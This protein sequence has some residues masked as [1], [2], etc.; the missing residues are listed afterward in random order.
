MLFLVFLAGAKQGWWKQLKSYADIDSTID[1]SS[2]G[3][4]ESIPLSEWH[5]KNDLFSTNNIQ[6]STNLPQD[7]VSSDIID[8]NDKV[9]GDFSFR[10]AGDKQQIGNLQT[11]QIPVL[12]SQKYRLTFWLKVNNR[13]CYVS[14]TVKDYDTYALG[15]DPNIYPP[16]FLIKENAASSDKVYC[17]QY[18]V[19]INEKNADGE[20]VYPITSAETTPS[21][22][23]YYD[24]EIIKLTAIQGQTTDAPYIYHRDISWFKEEVTFT[25]NSQTQNMVFA[26][27]LF[28]FMGDFLIDDIQLEQINS[29]VQDED[30][31]IP[32]NDKDM[33]LV[34]QDNLETITTSAKFN[35]DGQN[36]SGFHNS[37]LNLQLANIGFP[38]EAL[39]DLS[40]TET[41]EGYA[42]YENQ[43]LVLSVGADS[44][45]IIKLKQPLNIDVT[46]V[47]PTYSFFK[48]GLIFVRDTNKNTSDPPSLKYGNGFSFMPILGSQ[49]YRQPYIKASNPPSVGSQ[50]IDDWYWDP[51]ITTDDKLDPGYSINYNAQAGDAF[52]FTIFPP[53]EFNVQDFCKTRS[54]AIFYD[55]SSIN[56]SINHYTA[57]QYSDQ[58]N[59]VILWNQS[60]AWTDNFQ[61]EGFDENAL[62]ENVKMILGKGAPS[63]EAG[64]FLIKED[65]ANFKN[66]IQRM[67]NVGSKVLVY[68]SPAFFYTSKIGDPTADITDPNQID[69]LLSNLKYNLDK[70]EIDGVY[71]DGLYRKSPM[72]NLELMRKTRKLLGDKVFIQHES[73]NG[74]FYGNWRNPYTFLQSGFR[75]PVLDAYADLIWVGESEQADSEDVFLNKFAGKNLSNS[76]TVLLMENRFPLNLFSNPSYPD[77]SYTF[78]PGEID[79]DNIL[80]QIVKQID[81]LGDIYTAFSGDPYIS[82]ARGKKWSTNQDTRNYYNSPTY[83]NF[84]INNTNPIIDNLDYEDRLNSLCGPYINNDNVCD[85]SENILDNPADCIQLDSQSTLKKEGDQYQASSQKPLANWIISKREGDDI[86]QTPLFKLHYRADSDILRDVS[87]YKLDPNY[88]GFENLPQ[89]VIEDGEKAVR[90]DRSKNSRIYTYYGNENKKVLD[91]NNKSIS[92]FTRLKKI[93]KGG[94]E[95][96]YQRIFS[97]DPNFHF[98]FFYNRLRVYLP[99]VDKSFENDV[100]INDGL[101]HNIGFVYDQDAHTLA[102]YIDGVQTSIH[103][104]PVD[105]LE[106][107]PNHNYFNLGS[108][109]RDS[110]DTFDGFLSEF[111]IADSALTELQVIEMQESAQKTLSISDP[112][113]IGALPIFSDDSNSYFRPDSTVK[114]VD[115]SSASTNDILTYD[116]EYTNFTGKPI[117]NV[118]ITDN[119]P[120]GT[121]YVPDSASSGGQYSN[122]TI[123][124]HIDNL[125]YLETFKVQFQ[126][127]VQ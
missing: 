104:V 72:K 56:D 47:D 112:D 26:I 121:E 105:Y 86:T 38:A 71:F 50:I 97:Y 15:Y 111:Y 123:Q 8:Y 3:L 90:Y 127:K 31:K 30:L 95:D 42:I 62:P 77:I 43:N 57:N 94:E 45:M 96:I 27:N 5:Q 93:V 18:N 87:G 88:R 120:S 2:I 54:N 126:V 83:G 73:L 16:S 102:F 13:Q 53:K 69:S 34:F 81:N 109:G 36:I 29:F 46:G 25:S 85:V 9:A 98:I 124:W 68:M 59:T 23:K 61:F 75:L 28:G 118:T 106:F 67:H 107:D 70:Y 92:V 14:N 64:P 48:N 55:V 41:G 74:W 110:L 19:F 44:S 63:D 89:P 115:R 11:K 37:D 80:S 114:T 78:D 103:D 12:P 58:Y 79:G 65:D 100:I 108:S 17:G 4:E 35:Y 40:I 82:T 119:I 51:K 84:A 101:W 125:D 7:S 66:F 113:V 10:L 1:P 22:E 60:Y 116:V 39:A 6:Y 122:G 117:T 99:G 91:L 33:N 76:S 49:D 52:L 32:S 24:A 21:Q 20:N